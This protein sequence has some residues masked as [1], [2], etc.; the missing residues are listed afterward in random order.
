MKRG[1]RISLTC[2][3]LYSQN[4]PALPSLFVPFF[5]LLAL[6]CFF[7]SFFPSTAVCPRTVA[8]TIVVW[9]HKSSRFLA[10]LVN[11]RRQLIKGPVL[12]EMYPSSRL[13]NQSQRCKKGRGTRKGCHASYVLISSTL[14]HWSLIAPKKKH[15]KDCLSLDAADSQ[16]KEKYQL[17]WSPLILSMNYLNKITLCFVFFLDIQ[18]K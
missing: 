17:R 11:G 4:Q 6:T 2:I 10:T 8:Q 5:L 3:V 15:R 13:L 1:D 7:R 16:R 12:W 18:V 9:P 14:L